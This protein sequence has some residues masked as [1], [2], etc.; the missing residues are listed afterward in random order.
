MKL[1]LNKNNIQI[2]IDINFIKLFNIFIHKYKDNIIN[3]NN[4]AIKIIDSILNY[5]FMSSFI[6]LFII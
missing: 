5:L 2:Y 1:S 4:K 6:K 3:H